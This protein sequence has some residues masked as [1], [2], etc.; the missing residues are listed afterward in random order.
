ASANQVST[1]V[2]T[3]LYDSSL[4]ERFNASLGQIYYFERPRT[5]TASTIDQSDNRGSLSWAG[6]SYWKFA[7]NWGIRGGAQYD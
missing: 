6:D 2:T 5:G 1:G 7:D 4:E 3:R